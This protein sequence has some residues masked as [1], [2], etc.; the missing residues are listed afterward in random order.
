L[1]GIKHETVHIDPYGDIPS[2][3]AS[4]VATI[5]RHRSSGAPDFE[6]TFK[7]INIYVSIGLSQDLT[8]LRTKG[9]PCEWVGPWDAISLKNKP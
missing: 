8:V 6:D 3:L 1:E 9:R 4:G 2:H 7:G 5:C